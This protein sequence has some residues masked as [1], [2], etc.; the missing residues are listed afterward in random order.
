MSTPDTEEIVKEAVKS[1]TR[2]DDGL[3]DIG[4][5]DHKML[6]DLIRKA[7]SSR[8]TY[9]KERVRE[10]VENIALDFVGDSE[11]T[12]KQILKALEDKE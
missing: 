3:L 5:H 2:D 1:V 4:K 8:D 9:W 6:A 12:R 7:L 10:V 11:Q